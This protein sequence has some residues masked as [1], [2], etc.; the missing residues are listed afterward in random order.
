MSTQFTQVKHLL[1]KLLL[2][3][4]SFIQ[5]KQLKNYPSY[6]I[7]IN[8]RWR[9]KALLWPS[10]EHA[11]QLFP[12]SF[13]LHLSFLVQT[14][15]WYHQSKILVDD[16]CPVFL[17]LLQYSLLNT[18]RSPN[19]VPKI[20]K[21]SFHDSPS[22]CQVCSNLFQDPHIC[23]FIFPWHLQQPPVAPPFLHSFS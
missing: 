16:L 8:L 22:D 14:L 13:V 19:N 10:R 18:F 21:F 4:W 5:C 7:I 15:S 2:L 17:L 23:L 6:I 9:C 11:M 12:L 20:V 3:L 1:Y